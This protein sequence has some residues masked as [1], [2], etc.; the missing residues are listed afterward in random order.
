[1]LAGYGDTVMFCFVWSVLAGHGDRVMF[2]LVW[3]VL[4]GH[5]DTQCLVLVSVGWIW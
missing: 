5:D 4:A 1:M 3:S 2:D